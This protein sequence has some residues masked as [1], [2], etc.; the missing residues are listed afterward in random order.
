MLASRRGLLGPAHPSTLR[1]TGNLAVT[2]AR[3]GDWDPARRLH[4]SAVAGYR[5]VL[6]E[7]HVDTLDAMWELADTLLATGENDA[8]CGLRAGSRCGPPTSAR[9]R[10]RRHLVQA[11][12]HLARTF[13]GTG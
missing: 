4:E 11:M 8:A 6:G 1:A 13:P 9:P 5:E 7:D 3:L 2:L 10:P 12:A